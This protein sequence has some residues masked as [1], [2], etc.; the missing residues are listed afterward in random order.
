MKELRQGVEQT[1][2]ARPP[3]SKKAKAVKPWL[4]SNSWANCG[5]AREV[6]RCF[7]RYRSSLTRSSAVKLCADAKALRAGEGQT[8]H[9]MRSI[10]RIM[11]SQP[12]LH[13]SQVLLLVNWDLKN[14]IHTNL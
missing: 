10:F 9:K 14:K 5:A 1:H 12:K 11:T 8:H 6:R 3:E 13:F 4:E 2:K 7:K